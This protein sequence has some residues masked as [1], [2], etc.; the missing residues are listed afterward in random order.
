MNSFRNHL[1]AVLK[2][3]T[4]ENIFNLFERDGYLRFNMLYVSP[5]VL[6]HFKQKLEQY[7]LIAWY[8]NDQEL[9]FQLETMKILFRGNLVVSGANR[10]FS[11]ELNFDPIIPDDRGL[12]FLCDVETFLKKCD[13]VF[14]MTYFI[15]I[16]SEILA[17]PLSMSIDYLISRK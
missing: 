15:C 12:E 17:N 14:F 2:D 13:S 5:I 3:P 16:D 4:E 7:G 10:I 11:L 1:N 6:R 8:F 9:V